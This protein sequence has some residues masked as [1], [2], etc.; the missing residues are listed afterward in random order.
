ML[1]NNSSTIYTLSPIKK[2]KSLYLYKTGT[3]ICKF[4]KFRTIIAKYN[5]HITQIQINNLL[6]VVYVYIYIVHHYYFLWQLS[7]RNLLTGHNIFKIKCRY[8]SEIRGIIRTS[9]FTAFKG[10][11]LKYLLLFSTK[12]NVS[13]TRFDLQY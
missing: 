13:I 10:M 6:F 3:K 1:F 5:N 9:L 8:R 7:H 12:I 11:F 4:L 2:E